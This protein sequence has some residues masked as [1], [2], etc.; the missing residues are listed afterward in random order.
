MNE[1]VSRT[2]DLLEGQTKQQFQEA[3]A[4]YLETLANRID[5]QRVQESGAE[6]MTRAEIEA[7]AGPNADRLIARAQQIQGRETGEA[8]TAE[9]LADR[10]VEA[11]RRQEGRAGVDADA[12][13]ELRAERAIMMASEQTT[14]RESRDA[15]AASEAVRQLATHP[16]GRCPQML[17]RR[18][19]WRSFGPSRSASSR[20]SRRKQQKRSPVSR[21]GC[22]DVCGVG[23]KPLPYR[24][25]PHRQ[26][27]GTPAR[28]PAAHDRSDPAP[29]EAADQKRLHRKLRLREYPGRRC[30][31]PDGSDQQLL[32]RRT[33]GLRWHDPRATSSAAR[34]LS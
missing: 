29:P 18:M 23:H 6:T 31:S 1:A 14:T 9:R 10:A 16:R 7:I 30:F 20:K 19:P 15:V 5:L 21:N 24:R 11:E 12:V 28:S 3:S 4:R 22:R 25:V 26:R 13:R 32:K 8:A 2:G 34:S 33:S 17:G 27:T